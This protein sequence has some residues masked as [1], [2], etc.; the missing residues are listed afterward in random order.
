MKK[1][2]CMVLCTVFVL[3]CFVF[4]GCVKN[5]GDTTGE[6]TADGG[7]TEDTVTEEDTDINDGL[8]EVRYDGQSF[9]VL[10]QET[11]HVNDIYCE[12]HDTGNSIHDAVRAR[13]IDIE[14]RFGIDLMVEVDNFGSVNSKIDRM[15]KSGSDEF[16]LCFVHMVTG[17]SRA[18]DNDFVPFEKLPYVDLSKPWWDRQ[19]R[20]GF[21]IG[22]NLMMANGD[23]SPTSFNITSCLYF[24]KTLFDRYDMEYPYELV[25]QGK[26]TLDKLYEL[27]KDMTID[28]DGDGVLDPKSQRDTYCMST[29][30]YD[31]PYSLYYGSGGMLVS[32]DENDMPYYDP[33]IERDSAIYQKIYNII[34]NNN[35]YF[36]TNLSDFSNVAK[37]FFDGRALFYDAKLESSEDLREMDN[38]YGILPIPKFS[39][40]QND[41]YSFV[42]GATSMVCVPVT[43]KDLERAS[44]VIEALASGAYKTITP[45][46]YETYLKRKVTRDADSADMIEYIVRNRVFDMGYVNLFDGIGSFVREML[47]AKKTDVSYTFQKYKRK[48][49]SDMEKLVE[50]YKKSASS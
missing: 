17:A 37:V 46:L 32:K 49:Q 39:E 11:A 12:D 50:S 29:W 8:P 22:S 19:I 3:G 47:T 31:V 25:R 20:N 48:S 18:I 36:E 9:R 34:I 1:F 33:N 30:F 41:Y 6:S 7:D 42:N 45:V 27:T 16:D 38:E 43:C 40:L 5:P 44:V 14:E 10:T 2:V 4:T 13:N 24:N 23:I 26:W 15:V 28:G 35:A 21:S